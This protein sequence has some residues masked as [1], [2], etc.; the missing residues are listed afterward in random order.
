M[1]YSAQERAWVMRLLARLS[2]EQ[3]ARYEAAGR[4]APR[5]S[6]SGKLYDHAKAEIAE[7]ILYE[8]SLQETR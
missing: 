8:D 1:T 5:H 7:R 4:E 2:P 3:R 6:H